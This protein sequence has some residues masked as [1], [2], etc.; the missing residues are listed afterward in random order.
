MALEFIFTCSLASGLHARPAAHLAERAN[1]FSA[2]CFLT[3]LRNGREA[4]LKSPL[5]IIAANVRAGDRCCIRVTG[6]DQLLALASLRSFVE[7]DLPQSDEPIA[8][9]L[10]DDKHGIVPRDLQQAGVTCYYGHAVHRGLGQGKVV[11]VDRRAAPQRAD[12]E[13]AGDPQQEQKRVQA[14][15]AKVQSHLH[16]LL[17]LPGSAAQKAVLKAQ[18]SIAAD[19]SLADKLA[20]KITQ[21][22]SAGQAVQEAGDF[23]LA[24]FQQSESAYIRER[25]LDM[26]D[27]LQQLL[28]EIYG[29]EPQ[30]PSLQLAEPSIAVAETL[31]P[32]QLLSLDR[33]WLKAVVLESASTTAHAVILAGSLGIP[34]LVGV[35]EARRQLHP[36]RA[37]VVD[38]NRGF[39]VP[40]DAPA[41]AE[42][43]LREGKML[44]RRRQVLSAGIAHPVATADGHKIEVA[45]NIAGADELAQVLE[46][47]ADGIG[48]F[49]T[50]MLFIGRDS[51]PDEEEQFAVYK[52][53]AE[54]AHHRPV[55]LRTLDVGAD[56]PIPQLN[57]PKEN[58]PFL[59]YR[60][61]RLYPDFRELIHIQL[62][63]ALRASAFGRIQVMVP[64]VSSLE[65]VL[66]VKALIAQVQSE[67]TTG[68]I[69]FNP[70]M[71]LGVMIETPAAAF[72]L[73]ALCAELDF[74]SIGTND[75][76][77]YFFA[78]DRGNDRV[79]SLAQARHP[80]FLRFL[81]Q[82]VK[83]IQG[84]GKW[85]GMCGEMAA[86]PAN[87]A[88]LAGLGLNE[89]S[90]PASQIPELKQSLRRL[91]AR[92]CEELLSKA[93]ACE[94]SKDVEALL[95]ESSDQLQPLL[96]PDLIVVDDASENKRGAIREMVEAF[97]VSGRIND[98]QFVEE[99]IW[100]R[101]GISSTGLGYGFAIPH[102]KT[103]AVLADSIGILKFKRPIDW[104]S[105][106]DK[107]VHMI[108]L[109][110]VR[111]SRA[112]GIH[113]Q[114]LSRLARKLMDEEFRT[115]LLSLNDA[116]AMVSHLSREL[117]I[118]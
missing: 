19:I 94:H 110:A 72:L 81:R 39:V 55:I 66:W 78:A 35:K 20:E 77:Q 74:F 86:D 100:N 5:A 1:V 38:A 89:I 64:M 4:N 113:L 90:V 18:L 25:S 13:T 80:A 111:E 104:G 73:R 95:R 106:D 56:K 69:A 7:A 34:T 101:E 45:A 42:F 49:R 28:G 91:S 9:S 36:G 85:V 57:L 109:L 51:L 99:A 112:N 105:L 54:L 58:N 83:E 10:A 67:L 76:T 68:N 93:A 30:A 59:G 63:A 29:S 114:V 70:A 103:D 50:E 79:A 75:L 44:E 96:T 115:Q 41:V 87:L 24:V 118:K 27:V 31:S 47:G 53:A 61:V 52:Q 22:T 37:A 116:N 71:P 15:L 17:A 107:P 16:A 21:G 11:F 6:V 62:R 97:Y 32:Q 98:P 108:I 46:Q 88:L 48:L 8:P 117:E 14:A 65:E 12:S 26:Q 2:H 102:C 60:G 43:Y 82:I 84:A 3:N 23:F 33:Q 40:C 92:S